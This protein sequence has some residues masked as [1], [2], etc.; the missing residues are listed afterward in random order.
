MSDR[1]F[2]TN[3]RFVRSSVA[4]IAAIIAV[5]VGLGLSPPAG[6]AHA[7]L[8]RA[9]PPIDGL[10]ISSPNRISLTFTEPVTTTSP[11]PIVTMLDEKGNAIGENPVP[12]LESDDP[13]T[14]LLKTPDLQRGTYTV[15]W[16]VTSA[17]DGH[18]L[19]GVYAFRV[20]G[21]LPPGLASSSDD[22]PAVW[23][24]L[25]RWLT[26]LGSSLAA[27]L[28]L[29]G[30]FFV[31]DAAVTGNRWQHW[32]CRLILGGAGIALAATVAEPLVQWLVDGGSFRAVVDALPGGWWWRPAML[33]PL[34]VLGLAITY[35]MR[36]AIPLTAVVGGAALALG[37][38]LGLVMTSHAAGRAD[39]H[40]AAIAS[41]AFHQWAVAL[42]TGG[43]AALVIWTIT[44]SGGDHSPSLHLRK[45]S[46]TALALSAIAIATGVINTGF[47][48]PFIARVR[49][50]GPGIDV[51][52][53]LWT[54]NY[55]IALLIKVAILL[56]PLAL[57]VYHRSTVTRLGR[58]TA[59]LIGGLTGR[60]QRTVRWEV[61]AVAVVIVGGSTIALSAPPPTVEAPLEQI[62]L[63]AP[64]SNAPGPD[65]L[66]VHL[67]I[68][69]AD[70]GENTITA[71]LTNWDGAAIAEDS[72][73]RVVLDF[74]SLNHGTV[75]AGV[76]LHPAGG[77][78]NAFRT[79]GLDI[80]L[81][82]WWQIDARVMGAGASDDAQV[83]SF[84]AVLP[85]PNTQ[86]TDAAPK[87]EPDRGAEAL[88]DTAYM[89]MLAWDRVRWTE[90]LG[91]GN[92]A[93]VLA[94]FAVID[95]GEAGPDAH[96]LDLAYSG[97]F[98]PSAS[99]TPPQPPTYDSRASITIGDRGWLRA[100][101]GVWLEQP[102][103]S[104]STPS[105]WDSIYLGSDN[106][107][108]GIRQTIDGVELQVITFY[109]TEQPTRAGAWFVWW[110]DMS[111]GDVA[112]VAMIA[113]LHYMVWSYTDIDG[114]FT[115]EP[116]VGN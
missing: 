22:I 111:T 65:S 60:M 98:A 28:L 15:S 21:G 17:T 39:Q 105:E 48:F 95:N 56:I 11:A 43:L 84:F 53:P 44:R 103:T 76:N 57:A 109:L 107:Q 4:W 9:D 82:G 50:D 55:G 14:L 102:P 45:F 27:G 96:R 47:V 97:G 72:M 5:I 37:S 113:R 110:I 67:T 51:F 100:T 30:A 8:L 54:S 58:E 23:A 18:T 32:R 20:G 79:A 49:A 16:E 116:P 35:P 33:V 40:L 41:N 91:S 36:G 10:A 93:L 71:R 3:R 108:M 75:N 62:T 112:R 106:H 92:D 66:L 94:N 83:A 12:I 31:F 87:P 7:E 99:G 89:Q 29:F 13:R 73:A 6:L 101:N 74:T 88:F 69:P 86:G 38:L 34:T 80:S 61:A 85:D 42:W 1:D 46:S 64:T 59:S 70:S 78:S 114:D 19:N 2:M 81:E 104:Y 25:T 26:F 24:V 90:R 52:E 68:D 63:V 115:I 77:G